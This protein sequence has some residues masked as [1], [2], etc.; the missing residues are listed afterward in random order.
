M[1]EVDRLPVEH[2]GERAMLEVG[3]HRHEPV[4]GPRP[5]L[6]GGEKLGGTVDDDHRAG[7]ADGGEQRPGHAARSR[8]D[9]D[10][11]RPTADAEPLDDGPVA[12]LL[13]VVPRAQ[14]RRHRRPVDVVVR[15][16]MSWCR[17]A[18]RTSV[19]TRP[20]ARRSVRQEQRARPSDQ[21]AV[22]SKASIASSS[23]SEIG[24]APSAVCNS[25]FIR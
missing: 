1:D 24:R 18:H 5:L 14:R 17:L 2:V 6:G 22:V 21:L 7:A 12:L 4:A 3:V 10:R 15:V 11:H 23:R 25:G 19:A 8:A 16:T 13:E 20:G 9:V